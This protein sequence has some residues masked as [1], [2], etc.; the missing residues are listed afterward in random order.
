ML[1]HKSCEIAKFIFSFEFHMLAGEF[2]SFSMLCHFWWL[3]N[4]HS[5]AKWQSWGFLEKVLQPLDIQKDYFHIAWGCVTFFLFCAKENIQ[6]FK[7]ISTKSKRKNFK[8][9]LGKSKH[10][11][12]T[13]HFYAWISS[14]RPFAARSENTYLSQNS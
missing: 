8:T 12:F 4:L 11:R 6:S 1:C 2:W 9:R 5:K 10:L 7:V 3:K 13:F 14:S